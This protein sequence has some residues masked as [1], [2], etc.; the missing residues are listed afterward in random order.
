MLESETPL[1]RRPEL[2]DAKP[3]RGFALL[4]AK[5]ML[6][7]FNNEES[8]SHCRRSANWPAARRAWRCAPSSSRNL[9]A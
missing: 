5:P 1:R 7:V 3:L 9:R 6:V 8:D 2:A 4:T